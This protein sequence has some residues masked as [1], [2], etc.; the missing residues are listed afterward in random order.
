MNRKI[1]IAGGDLRQL[2]VASEFKDE[3]FDIS[4]YGFCNS[5][6]SIPYY[7][8]SDFNKAVSDND[9]IISGMPVSRDNIFLNA[10]YSDK[11]VR[12]SEVSNALNSTKIFFGGIIP[13]EL[14]KELNSK[15]VL[16]FDYGLR[17]ELTIENV[18]PTVEGAVSIAINET[19]FTLHGSSILICG[20]G[21]IGKILSKI[22]K[23]MGAKVTVSARK[24]EDLSWIGCLGYERIKTKNICESINK[25]DIIFNTVPYPVIDEESLKRVKK[26]AVI[27]DL[28]S[29]PGGVDF[30][31]AKLLDIK[32][33]RALSLPG[34]T[35]P[36][37]AGRIIKNTIS[38]ILTE[39][40]V[41]LWGI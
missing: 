22:L 4:F 32:V 40:G 12:I 5:N 16:C 18:I 23:S 26:N 11:A 29:N 28:A 8:H 30:R 38:N 33:I 20:F 14:K 19:P 37:T 39:L 35:A 34:K 17:E 31:Y 41:K 3:G 27:I 9:I 15:N 6:I 36:E 25:F 13:D 2:T 7:I 1:L 21:R 24:S 10:P